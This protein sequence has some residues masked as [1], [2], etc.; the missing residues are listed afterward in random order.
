M[1]MP[2]ST[3]LT[4]FRIKLF[5]VRVYFDAFKVIKLSKKLLFMIHR[6]VSGLE[7]ARLGTLAFCI[8]R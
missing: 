6:L 8:A 5:N 3:P 1:M 4:P 7:K 2:E